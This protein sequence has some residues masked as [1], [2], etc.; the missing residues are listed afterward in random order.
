[1][2]PVDTAKKN[3]RG[4]VCER[5]RERVG[6]TRA[7]DRVCVCVCVCVCV[8][9]RVCVKG[10]EADAGTVEQLRERRERGGSTCPQSP[11]AN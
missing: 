3:E 9:A 5:E 1:V 6:V 11:I 4:R 10:D 2:S 8:R 7:R